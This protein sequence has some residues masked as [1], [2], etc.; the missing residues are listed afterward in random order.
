MKPVQYSVSTLLQY[1]LENKKH[2]LKMNFMDSVIFVDGR[3]Y[4]FVATPFVKAK[5]GSCWLDLE[6]FLHFLHS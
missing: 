1:K 2:T 6:W 5:L 3:G 4:V